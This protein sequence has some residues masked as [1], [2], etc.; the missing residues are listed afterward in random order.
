MTTMTAA[1][2]LTGEYT[3]DPAHSR[4]GFVARHAMVTKVRGSFNEFEGSG[5]FD[6]EDPSRSTWR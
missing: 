4:I 1:E 5:Y 3:I 6:A 2:N